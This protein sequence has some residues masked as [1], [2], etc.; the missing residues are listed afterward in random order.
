LWATVCK[1]FGA[2]KPGRFKGQIWAFDDFDKTPP[3]VINA[4]EDGD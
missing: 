1:E 3:S 4:F 2:R